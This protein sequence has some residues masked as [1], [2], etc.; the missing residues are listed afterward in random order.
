MEG[1][2]ERLRQKARELGLSDA[3]V[4]RRAGLSERRYGNYV[5]GIR[6]P[7]LATLVKIAAALSASPNQLLLREPMTTAKSDRA[8][9]VARLMGVTDALPIDDLER[10]LVQ[11]EALAKYRRSS[12]RRARA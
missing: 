4:A 10:V 8:K 2:P 5:T 11:V 6:E 3:D 12:R 9:M 1:L 7:D